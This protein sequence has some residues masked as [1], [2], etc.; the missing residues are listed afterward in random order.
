MPSESLHGCL[1]ANSICAVIRFHLES[2]YLFKIFFV[3]KIA[4]ACHNSVAEKLYISAWIPRVLMC[5]LSFFSFPIM[6]NENWSRPLPSTSFPN[7]YIRVSS[8]FILHMMYNLCHDRHYINW[9]H[10]GQSRS[11]SSSPGRVKNL[12]FSTS[13]RLALGSTQPHIKWVSVALS[14]GVKQPGREAD[15]SSPTSTE[16][17]KMWIYTSTLPYGFIA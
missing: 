1:A 10:A 7:R 6:L 9:L 12:L 5:I 15:R 17:K 2:R 13:S 3:P 16:V 14:P 8:N 4:A 11:R